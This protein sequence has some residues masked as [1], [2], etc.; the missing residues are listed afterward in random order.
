M[1]ECLAEFCRQFQSFPIHKAN[2]SFYELS[3]N[4]H[5]LNHFHI[6]FLFSNF[7]PAFNHRY[8]QT[9]T[10]YSWN[11]IIFNLMRI[12]LCVTE[13]VFYMISGNKL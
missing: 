4:R 8:N 9:I 3:E 11:F 12:V 1:L 2:V 7:L 13:V 6:A 10:L 5:G